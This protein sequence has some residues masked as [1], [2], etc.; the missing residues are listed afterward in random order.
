[1]ETCQP[2]SPEI[3]TCAPIIGRWCPENRGNHH[4]EAQELG[5]VRVDCPENRANRAHSVPRFPYSFLD[6]PD[7]SI[8]QR[9]LK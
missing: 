1:M 5:S 7:G 8:Q 2:Q 4:E 3:G 6:L 9:H